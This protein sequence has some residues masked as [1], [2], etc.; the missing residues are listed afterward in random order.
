MQDR[1]PVVIAAQKIGLTTAISTC[2]MPTGPNLPI[3]SGSGF[4]SWAK[5][6][7]TTI[8]D[9]PP[10]YVNRERCCKPQLSG[11]D[12]EAPH[13]ERVV[14]SSG[15]V[16]GVSSLSVRN[17]S[18]EGVDEFRSVIDDLTIENME[19]KR[20]LRR[21]ESLHCSHLESDKLFEIKMHSLPISKKRELEALLRGFAMDLGQT[22]NERGCSSTSQESSDKAPSDDPS[23]ASDT[24]L[25]DSAYASLSASGRNSAIASLPGHNSRHPMSTKTKDQELPT[26]RG[27]TTG[28][29]RAKHAPL[30]S[31]RARMK[32]VVRRL[33]QLF[34]GR[35][36]AGTRHGPPP[37]QQAVS[38]PAV[39]TDEELGQALG[40]G[41]REAFILSGAKISTGPT[42][43]FGD[44]P[45]SPAPSCL[46]NPETAQ[47]TKPGAGL[48]V[49]RA[50]EQRP[51]RP[52]DLDLNRAQLPA[53]NI[54]YIR[55]LG[56]CSPKQRLNTPNQKDEGWVYLNV[57][58]NMAQLH[59][60][61]VTPEFV[62]KAITNLSDKLELSADGR[63]IRWKGG[64]EGTSL[65][66]DS[67]GISGGER[68]SPDSADGVNV[69]CMKRRKL[70][71]GLYE[72][73]T[74]DDSPSRPEYCP[75]L[76]P[77]RRWKSRADSVRKAGPEHQSTL[78]YF[79]KEDKFDYKPLF[80][81]WEDC[82][83]YAEYASSGN[84]RSACS[85]EVASTSSTQETQQGGSYQPLRRRGGDG[86]IIF[87][88]GA[89][90]CADLS[91]DGSDLPL[92]GYSSPLPG[93]C[94]AYTRCGSGILGCS[95]TPTL[96]TISGLTNFSHPLTDPYTTDSGGEVSD[97]SSDR[98]LANVKASPSFKI[99]PQRF[100][101][102]DEQVSPPIELEAS[103]IGRVQPSDNFAINV[104]FTVNGNKSPCLETHLPMSSSRIDG[105][106]NR[107]LET[108]VTELKKYSPTTH[109]GLTKEKSDPPFRYNVISATQIDLPPFKL[110]PPTYF[111]RASSPSECYSSD[112]NR[113]G[114]SDTNSP[115]HSP[116]NQQSSLTESAKNYA[117]VEVLPEVSPS[118][119]F[120]ASQHTGAVART[121]SKPKGNLRNESS[122]FGSLVAT[123]DWSDGSGYESGD[124]DIS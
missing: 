19:L 85:P 10:Y 25:R 106:V 39:R 17:T 120:I 102:D 100:I 26:R 69:G 23:P 101:I 43:G 117:N 81:H 124:D 114:V 51:T 28:R 91:G 71:Y 98:P 21:F 15:T 50:Q 46:E 59:T 16:G 113:S 94:N 9:D 84:C 29:L 13:G 11:Y 30:V 53:E 64:N 47:P 41:S 110:P 57:L 2:G 115:S 40:E 78:H 123:A 90:F 27:N 80:F 109:P 83:E 118:I 49:D 89:C 119:N 48:C 18:E 31:E 104:S 99:S 63:K 122:K 34:T 20:R 61:N 107:I 32:P 1:V 73:R 52:L 79:L 8:L 74:G 42:I 66:S 54:D 33:E 96:R 6:A 14:P 38:Q 92:P 97:A 105:I 45:W 112:S 70:G 37:Q 55:H 3:V 82:G 60:I 111:L 56:M 108:Q 36:A 35:K 67:G 65:T 7:L 44:D 87:F 5:P 88:N 76:I 86:S 4:V 72:R 93:S 62:R 68:G 75:M 103:G 116:Y 95:R 24:K 12:D 77:K 58:T 22:P 121:I